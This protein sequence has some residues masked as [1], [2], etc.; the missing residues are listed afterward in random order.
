MKLVIQRVKEASCL[1]NSKITGKIGV[2]FM[3]LVGIAAEDER[4]DAAYLAKKVAK[5]RVFDDEEG[6]MNNDL[7]AVQGAVLSISQFTLLA[8]TRKGNR[9]SFVKAMRG[10]DAK[11][12]YEYFNEQLRAEG[13]I[14]QTGIFGADMQIS[15]VNDGPVTILMES[16]K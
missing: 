16:E 6:K 9:P 5:L 2:G 10:E 12:L 3:I 1:V 8:D 4:K 14:V 15:L 7:R 13:Y 11:Q